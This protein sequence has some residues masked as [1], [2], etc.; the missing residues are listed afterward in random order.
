MSIADRLDPDLVRALTQVSGTTTV[1]QQGQA[2]PIDGPRSR[3][4]HRSGDVARQPGD[5]AVPPLLP[6]RTEPGFKSLQGVYDRMASSRRTHAS[7]ANNGVWFR[8]EDTPVGLRI[9]CTHHQDLIVR[10]RALLHRSCRC[11]GRRRC[12]VVGG[13]SHRALVVEIRCRSLRAAV[14]ETVSDVWPSLL[15]PAARLNL[16]PRVAKH[17]GASSD[18]APKAPRRDKSGTARK[19]ALLQPRAPV[20][21]PTA[22]PLTPEQ[23]ARLS[24]HLTPPAPLDP[25]RRFASGYWHATRTTEE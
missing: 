9:S 5:L 14:L 7:V 4:P 19:P 17:K 8:C 25:S 18:Q 11:K 20:V 6:R 16:G 1:P 15:G 3:S 23:I 21:T 22:R 2:P 24:R 10:L 13:N 12:S